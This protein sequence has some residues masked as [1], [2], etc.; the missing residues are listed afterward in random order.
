MEHFIRIQSETELNCRKCISLGLLRLYEHLLNPGKQKP[1]KRK[2]QKPTSGLSLRTVKSLK[3]RQKALAKMVQRNRFDEEDMWDMGVP[4]S[5]I[6]YP[7]LH[8]SAAKLFRMPRVLVLGFLNMTTELLEQNLAKVHFETVVDLDP[9]YM[10]MG[11]GFDGLKA[12]DILK[13]L[14]NNPNSNNKKKLIYELR[15]VVFHRGDNAEYGHYVCYRREWKESMSRTGEEWWYCNDG[16]TM[17]VRKEDFL[18]TF[19][20][21]SGIYTQGRE[22]GN[23]VL[24]FYEQTQG[25]KSGRPE[26]SAGDES[27]MGAATAWDKEFERLW[28]NKAD[29]EKFAIG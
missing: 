8:A 6:S 27:E 5:H 28:L 14:P 9:L 24:M 1:G 18:G 7:S 23:E 15:S 21:E 13:P 2:R 26:T 12:D 4:K 22:V 20:K 10:S 3:R 11:K 16:F 25:E 17:H 19:D 29:L